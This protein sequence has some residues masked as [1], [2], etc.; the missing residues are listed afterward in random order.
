[1][2][3]ARRIIDPEDYILSALSPLS[4]EGRLGAAHKIAGEAFSVVLLSE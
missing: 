1:M 2:K 4:P 3:P